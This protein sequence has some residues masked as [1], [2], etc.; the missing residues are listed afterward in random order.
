M[1]SSEIIFK[2]VLYSLKKNW[3]IF[4]AILVYAFF[5]FY[6]MGPSVT[7]CSTTVYSF[8]D[9]TAGPIWSASLPEKQGLT[10]SFTSMTNAPF[11]DNLNSPI[12]YSLIAQ[13]ALVKTT[14]AIA[15][16]ICGYNI[17]NMLG[18]MLSAL[19]MCGFIYEVTKNKWIALLAGYAASFAP[20]YQLKIGAHF[21]FGFQVIFIG[22]IWSFYRMMKYHKKRDAILTGGLF[23]LAVYWDPYYSLLAAIVV[24]PLGL[25]WLIMNR[26]IF[27]RSFWRQK[28][29]NI[30]VKKQFKLLTTAAIIAVIMMIP[31]VS[32]F[33]TQGKQISANVAN[34][35]GNVLLEAQ[36]CSTWPHEYLIPFAHNPIIKD[37]VG[38]ESYLSV[39]S[40]LR[41]HYS[42]GIG[43]DVI[44]LSV[45]LVTIMLLGVMA[46]IWEKMNKRK[47]KLGDYLGFEPKI[48]IYG[49]VAVGVTAVLIGFPPF[50]Y[51][52]II[53]T[54]SYLL[55]KLTLTWRTL[56][57]VFV[58]VNIAVI[59]L[60]AISLTYFYKHSNFKKYKILSVILYIVIFSAVVVEYQTSLPF[61]GNQFGTFD[62]T[63]S[64][65]TEYNWLKNQDNIKTI[66]EYP[67]ERSGGE[68]NSMA[69][70]LSM[71]V[72]HKKKLFNGALSYSP[73]EIMKTGLKN[74]YDPQTIPV[75]K[76][77][78]VDAIVVHGVSTED[79][80]R[81]PNVK[82]MYSSPPS[83]FTVAGFSPIVTN[84]VVNVISLENVTPQ[85]YVISLNSAFF[86][87]MSLISSAI[88]W[89]YLAAAGSVIKLQS[90]KGSNLT[91]AQDVCFDIKT[92]VPTEQIVLRP[93]VDGVSMSD[94]LLDANYKTIRFTVKNSIVLDTDPN[95]G[96]VVTKVGCS[97]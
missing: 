85:K 8:G 34:S 74:L 80:E 11:G 27:K 52:N 77:M 61:T 86:R 84:D 87:H 7:S 60:S 58:I 5:T 62:Y 46:I 21:S 76:G 91:V 66:A 47:T 70:Y 82:I 93:K 96:M 25:T 6:Y 83:G 64:V 43:E 36:Y 51:H 28:T 17:A 2:K 57:R 9:N 63:S 33:S 67:L 54:P 79:L 49:L 50:I 12:G 29:D 19:V 40:F 18:F 75:L 1:G 97:S 37:I 78:G 53:P 65:S 16:P 95:S 59:A 41:D 73:Q 30:G 31:L 68:G 35:R 72:V 10:G 89:R 88:D 14:M 81:I 20:Y 39:V 15:G 71:Q 3:F 48:L 4:F 56:E 55:L 23:G 44:G 26:R 90:L 38:S 92:F 22:I 32:I 45:T 42:C 13:T 69:Y 94:I 24:V